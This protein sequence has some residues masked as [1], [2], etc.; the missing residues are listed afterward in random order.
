VQPLLPK[1]KQELEH[2]ENLGVIR[3][4]DD[5]EVTEYLSPMVVVPKKNGRVRICVDLTKLNENVMRPRHQL[6]SVD[7]TLARLGQ[8]KIFSKLDAN[9][10]FFQIPL[11]KQSQILT[12][13]LTPF[14]RYCHTRLP[15]G[16]TSGPEFFQQKMDAIV[17][18]LP[19]A[20]CLIDD[21]AIASPDSDAE[22]HRTRLYPVLQRLQDAGVTLN[23]EKCEFFASG[24]TF[25]GHRITGAGIKADDKKVTAVR[26]MPQPQNITDLRPFLGLCQQLAKFSHKLASLMEPLR[27]LLSSK[28][29][30]LWCESHTHA[31]KTLKPSLVC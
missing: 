9:S 4:L 19:Q 3:R 21:I 24:V 27:A 13:F 11:A 14:G 5:D 2:M 31:F 30:F 16:I 6:P 15:F 10:G 7:E 20:S 28:N 18:D 23:R 25:V 22:S 29:E 17:K 26:D 12:S 8:G 1:V